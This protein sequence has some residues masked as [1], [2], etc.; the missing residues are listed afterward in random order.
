MT[1]SLTMGDLLSRNASA[2]T[3]WNITAQVR[4][5]HDQVR[6]V[7]GYWTGGGQFWTGPDD[8]ITSKEEAHELFLNGLARHVVRSQNGRVVW[9]GRITALQLTE[10]GVTVRRDLAR[11]ANSIKIIYSH[12]TGNLLLNGS[13][14]IGT[15][16][17]GNTPPN[18]LPWTGTGVHNY[19]GEQY[20]D[21]GHPNYWYPELSIVTTWKSAGAKSFK[22]YNPTAEDEFGGYN[23]IILETNTNVVPDGLY[24]Y[25]VTLYSPAELAVVIQF[26]SGT[27]GE[28]GGTVLDQQ[29][30]TLAAATTTIVSGDC[31][32]PSA[33]TGELA[34]YIRDA[35]G[36]V[37]TY[38]VDGATVQELG[39][40]KET[41]I[42]QNADSMALYGLMEEQ[43]VMGALTDEEALARQA[44]ILAWM[45]W[46]RSYP[47][48]ASVGE[49]REGLTVE[50][51]GYVFSLAR[52]SATLGGAKGVSTHLTDMIAESELVT[53]GYVKENTLSAY[54]SED[55]PTRLWDAVQQLV[56]AGG[57]GGTRC[58]GGVYAGRKLNYDSYPAAASYKFKGG[59]WLNMDNSPADPETML[60]GIVYLEDLVAGPGTPVGGALEDDPRYVFIA[61]WEYDADSNTVK[62]LDELE[63]LSQ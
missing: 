44:Q 15:I 58:L 12:Y 39:T 52:E 46:P 59:H 14:E 34:L 49:P 29:N 20:W 62:P 51:S 7:G 27:G 50:C 23:G 41:D 6:S 22:M 10:N 53:A 5:W 28:G 61:G 57:T 35:V 26:R 30:I 60:P 24:R 13:A 55:E 45:A 16:T 9:E 1:Y 17:P 63:T 18:A 8:K 11:M 25:R 37:S 2:L 47:V 40:R 42:S 32:A 19:R 54:I 43:I 36:S 21:S 3:P 31:T 4:G 56:E 38:Y 48:E 33:A